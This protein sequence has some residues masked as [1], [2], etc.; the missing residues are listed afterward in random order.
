MSRQEKLDFI[1]AHAKNLI[2]AAAT[3]KA[4]SQ[5][6]GLIGATPTATVWYI[7]AQKYN[8][9]TANDFV[10]VVQS[11]TGYGSQSLAPFRT[12]IIKNARSTKKFSASV[13]F[14]SLVKAFCCWK[15]GTIPQKGVVDKGQDF[16]RI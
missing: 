16:P 4:V 10:E 5:K 7:I 14:A 9:D 13:A 1:S 11:G 8:K 2:E 12:A 3:A 6:Y 15:N